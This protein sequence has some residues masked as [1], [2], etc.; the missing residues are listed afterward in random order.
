MTGTSDSSRSG[1]VD[2]DRLLGV[3]ARLQ[4]ITAALAD[5]SDVARRRV[6]RRV[7]RIAELA[8]YDLDAAEAALD[9]LERGMRR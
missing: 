1:L 9:R 3:R 5:Y 2:A 4:Q 7:E 6:T 8:P